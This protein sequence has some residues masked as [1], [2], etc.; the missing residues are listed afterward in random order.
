[1]FVSAM[2]LF[3]EQAGRPLSL[4]A[5]RSNLHPWGQG[6]CFASLATTGGLGSQ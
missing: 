4:R 2:I 6:D 3:C 1:M 5:K